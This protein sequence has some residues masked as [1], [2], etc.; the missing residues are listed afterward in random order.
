MEVSVPLLVCSIAIAAVCIGLAWFVR[1]NY[2]RSLTSVAEKSAGLIHF[3]RAALRELLE[4]KANALAVVSG[5]HYITLHLLPLFF[6][7]S[8]YLRTDAN[9]LVVIVSIIWSMQLFQRLFP[10]EEEGSEDEQ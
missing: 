7:L 9:F 1:Q 5:I 4:G 6:G 10:G 8:L 3:Y 2:V